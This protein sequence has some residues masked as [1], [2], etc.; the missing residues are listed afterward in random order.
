MKV[1]NG[2]YVSL[3]TVLAASTL[4]SAAAAQDA[5]D[6]ATQSVYADGWADG[7]NGG[8]GFG[9]WS[10]S[11]DGDATALNSIYA[12]DPHFIDG[13]GVGPLGAN[14]L[15]TPAFGLTT[16]ASTGASVQAVRAFDAPMQPG[17]RFT[18]TLDG[19][20]LEGDPRIGNRFEL[21]GADGVP[22]YTL[23]TS[24][25][26]NDDDWT[27]N[28]NNLSI[29]AGDAFRVSFTLQDIDSF[30]ASTI[31]LDNTIGTFTAT[32]T[33]GGTLGQPIDRIRFISSGTGS[34]ADGAREFF[35]DDLALTRVPEPASMLL[36]AIA[37]L[38]AVRRRRA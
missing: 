25:G 22:R 35:F 17:D 3:G 33:L 9:P 23:R 31:N 14:Q 24:L 15:G 36:S 27:Q 16:D 21:L 12:S 10:L 11:F 19:S 26:S 29:P 20:A 5:I 37:G 13:V 2:W 28:G 34:S 7:D 1:L 30:R 32:T 4:G 6:D 8:T 18:I 38:V